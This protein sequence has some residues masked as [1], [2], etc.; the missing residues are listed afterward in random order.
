MLSSISGMTSKEAIKKAAADRGMSKRDVYS[1][2]HGIG[3]NSDE[4]A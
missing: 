2:Y 3:G 4:E 1:E